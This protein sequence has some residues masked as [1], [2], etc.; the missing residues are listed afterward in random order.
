MFAI[1]PHNKLLLWVA[2]WMPM[3]CPK[4][5][6]LWGVNPNYHDSLALC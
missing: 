3:G 5:I 2:R 6:W 4:I 1:H